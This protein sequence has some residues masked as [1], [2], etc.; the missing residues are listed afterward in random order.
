[1]VNV[2]TAVLQLAPPLRELTCHV[3]SHSVI[4]HAVEYVQNQRDEWSLVLWLELT[5]PCSPHQ[6]TLFT[7][8]LH[9]NYLVFI[10]IQPCPGLFM[11]KAWFK[12]A[13]RRLYFLK[14]LKRAG[15]TSTHLFHY[16]SVVIGPVLEYCA[17]VWH[18]AITKPQTQQLE[19]IQRGLPNY[20]KFFSR[21]VVLTY[22][23]CCRF[24][25]IVQS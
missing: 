5:C 1:M 16:Y 23:I 22:A 12:K 6:L 24:D 18:Y 13:T 19:A 15:L 14:P 21:N 2:R 10:L 11:L 3:G 7:G 4:W 9:S 8:L 17:P 20:I 25:H